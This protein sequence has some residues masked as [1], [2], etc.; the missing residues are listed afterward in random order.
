MKGLD[1]DE[2]RTAE[3]IPGAESY[4]WE[5]GK[6]IAVCW[7]DGRVVLFFLNAQDE[8]SFD[9]EDGAVRRALIRH[10]EKLS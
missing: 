6:E 2:A 5:D 7:P 8:R 1:L 4:E 9:L 10:L 3:L